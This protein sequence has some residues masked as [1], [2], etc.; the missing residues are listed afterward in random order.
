[1]GVWRRQACL[2]LLLIVSGLAAAWPAQAR[3]PVP[4]QEQA[5]RYQLM[6]GD[7]VRN[8]RTD[9]VFDSDR[10]YVSVRLYSEHRPLQTVDSSGADGCRRTLRGYGI[11]ATVNTCSSPGPVRVT[12][13][14]LHGAPGAL[15]ISCRSWPYLDAGAGTSGAGS[16]GGMQAS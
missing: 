5:C 13:A 16:S 4:C 11:E 9:E 12:A 8:F 3:A 14:R 10:A 1:M 2:A 7:T 15:T 6:V